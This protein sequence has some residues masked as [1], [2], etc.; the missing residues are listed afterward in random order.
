MEKSALLLGE[1]AIFIFPQFTGYVVKLGIVAIPR[2]CFFAQCTHRRAEIIKSTCQHP[3]LQRFGMILNFLQPVQILANQQFKEIVEKS[4]HAVF[5]QTLFFHN[6][7]DIR[8]NHL[9]VIHQH[10]PF[11]CHKIAAA[12]TSAVPADKRQSQR[13]TQTAG[14]GLGFADMGISA[15][16][17]MAQ[18]IVK[19][20]Q[21]RFM[22]QLL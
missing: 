8:L 21:R 16:G 22:Y 9:A 4:P 12:E 5:H 7:P 13:S 20:W 2:H 11:L 19:P 14:A 10:H 6:M 3:F 15:A 18:H 1:E 17:R